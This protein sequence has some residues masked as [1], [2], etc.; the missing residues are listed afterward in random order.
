MYRPEQG[1]YS[2][3]DRNRVLW[4][5]AADPGGTRM[6]FRDGLV[7]VH[8][9]RFFFAIDAGSGALRWAHAEK[10]AD[11]VVSEHTGRALIFATADGE[12]GALDPSTGGELY[13]ARIPGAT[14]V[15]GA[16]FDAEGFRGAGDAST[17]EARAAARR[18]SRP[19]RDPG[20]DH[21]GHRPSVLR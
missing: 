20:R 12:I 5:A 2:A 15:R 10:A 19:A 6:A 11:A 8:D 14:M 7:F 9:F 17:V 3:I 1:D 18:G 4:R 13:R 21:L 16:T